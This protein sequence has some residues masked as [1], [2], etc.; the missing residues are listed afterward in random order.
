MLALLER[1]EDKKFELFCQ[2][3]EANGQAGVVER[4][5]QKY[6]HVCFITEQI[7]PVCCIAVTELMIGPYTL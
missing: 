6:R 5:L 1:T 2:A 7:E 4:H 3:L